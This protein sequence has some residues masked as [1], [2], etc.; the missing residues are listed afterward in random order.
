MKSSKQRISN[1]YCIWE[2]GPILGEISLEITETN[3]YL[4][5]NNNSFQC[6]HNYYKG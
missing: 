6:K 3:Q 4:E 5:T 1:S 2:F